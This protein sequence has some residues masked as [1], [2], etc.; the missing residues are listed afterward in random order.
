MSQLSSGQ[1]LGPVDVDL[2]PLFGISARKQGFGRV[3]SVSPSLLSFSYFLTA[4]A[5][6]ELSAASLLWVQRRSKVPPAT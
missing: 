4:D 5:G 3:A 6:P 1:D 2:Y